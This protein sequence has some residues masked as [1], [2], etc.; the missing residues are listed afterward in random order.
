ME[1]GFTFI[2]RSTELK[3]LLNI[4]SSEE[5]II[6]ASLKQGKIQTSSGDEINASIMVVAANA[7]KYITFPPG[8]TVQVKVGEEVVGCPVPPC[9]PGEGKEITSDCTNEIN[10]TLN[11][12]KLN[13]FTDGFNFK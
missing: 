11:S 12:Y 8:A 4:D 3:A 10:K 6:T 1:N 7:Y 5:V 13:K 9:K 2:F